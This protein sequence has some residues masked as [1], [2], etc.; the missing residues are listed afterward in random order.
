MKNMKHV[1]TLSIM[2]LL[3][4][5]AFCISGCDKGPE[6]A[7]TDQPEPTATATP[8]PT[9]E[10]DYTDKHIKITAVDSGY[11]I[12]TPSESVQW[13][14]RYGPAILLNE[15]GSIDAYFASP[16]SNNST[17]E[18]DWFT[19][20]H[21]DD[22]GK[23][24]TKEKVVLYPTPGSLDQLSVCDPSVFY[25]DGYYYIGYTSTIDSTS[26]GLCNSTFVARSKNPDG[27]FEKW[28]GSGWGGDPYP[29]IYYTG[30]GT[31]WGEGE[32]SFVILDGTIYV[33]HSM[34]ASSN[35]G[36]RL[37]ATKVWTADITKENWPA[38]LEYKGHAINRLESETDDYTYVEAD[39]IDV[40][41]VEKYKKFI[42]IGTNRRF[43]N[44]SCLV[45]YESN[46]GLTFT[47]VSEIN[48][49][50][51]CGSHNAGIMK[52]GNGHIKEGDPMLVGYAYAGS[53]N[54][55]WGYW[56]T[57]FAPIEITVTDEVDTSECE[58]ANL[59]QPISPQ[60]SPDE[61]WPIAL[62]TYP[63]EYKANVGG[64]DF[65]LEIYW[66]DTD[67]NQTLIKDSSQLTFSDYDKTIISIKGLTVTPLKEGSTWVTVK[68]KDLTQ[69]FLIR[70]L[71]KGVSATSW[72]EDIVEFKPTV[73]EYTISLAQEEGTQIRSITRLAN[74]NLCELYN[75]GASPLSDV[76]YKLT[77]SVED[78]SIC[79]VT[80]AGY[81]APR[82]VGET[83]VTVKCNDLSFD[84]KVKIVE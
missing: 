4:L 11:D 73:E 75:N 74:G 45:Y 17:D 24:W 5:V 3:L 52:D 78:K 25:Y 12:F 66:Y 6:P 8:V 76:G 20:K 77:F 57:R 31:S 69:K 32:P 68:Y 48:T 83:T 49:N 80:A 30:L 28:N 70:I 21:S 46:D 72:K 9:P 15:D 60:K 64:K 51:I 67:Y 55:K 53:N 16:G 19:Y 35:S 41:Y 33:Y 44:N 84:V 1:C 38:E 39:S 37:K 47:R 2:L 29:I 7:V 36:D 63:H 26:G 79:K 50:I 34:D 62:T 81:I 14:Y 58:A 27:P 23:T 10:I 42:A 59:K 40:A 18:L 65:S 82:A 43:S 22:G 56:A 13:A 71:P 54:N 61:P